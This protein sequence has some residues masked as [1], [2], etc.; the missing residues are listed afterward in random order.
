MRDAFAD[1]D[2]VSVGK[3]S[4]V[5]IHGKIAGSEAGERTAH[6]AVE[7]VERCSCADGFANGKRNEVAYA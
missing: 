1:H 6:A 7:L 2:R 3:M 5:D 4:T